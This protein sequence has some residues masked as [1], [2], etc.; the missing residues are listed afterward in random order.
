MARRERQKKKILLLIGLV[1]VLAVVGVGAWQFKKMQ[2]AKMVTQKRAAGLAA[3]EAGDHEAAFR[4]LQYVHRKDRTDGEVALALAESRRAVPMLNN[5]HLSQAM[6]FAR[7]AV[8][9][10]PDNLETQQ[11]LMSI[12]SE[13]GQ[14]TE[15]LSA[16]L[17]VQRIDPGN[18]DAIWVEIDSLRLLGRRQE[19]FDRALQF[20]EMFPTDPDASRAVVDLMIATNR[21]EEDVIA[22]VEEASAT[23][24]DVVRIQ[25]LKARVYGAYGRIEE[26]RA[27][28]LHAA[29]MEQNDAA[30]LA[31]TIQL[32]DVLG[33]TATVDELLQ[34]ESENPSESDMATVVAASRAWKDARLIDAVRRLNASERSLED[35]SSEL[36]AWKAIILDEDQ[37]A[38]A[39]AALRTR[40]TDEA[41]AWVATLDARERIRAK[42][43]TEAANDA[44][45]AG[46]LDPR[47][48]MAMFLLGETERAVGDWRSAIDRWRA[49]RIVE[50]RWLTLRLDIVSALLNAG[51]TREAYTEAIQ[52]FREWPDRLIVAQALGRSG[53]SLMERGQ[54]TPVERTQLLNVLTEIERQANDPVVGLA[55]LTRAHAA[56]GDIAMARETLGRLLAEDSLPPNED[57]IPLIEACRQAEIFGV[58][59]LV[60]KASTNGIADP[61]LI[62]AAAMVAHANGRSREGESLIDNAIKAETTDSTHQLALKRIRAIYF[63]RTGDSRALDALKE[64]AESDRANPEAQLALLNSQAAWT[65]RSAVRS[66]ITA[67]RNSSGESSA[68]WKVFEAR[69]VLTFEPTE[70]TAAQVVTLLQD[71]VRREP[72]NVGALTFLGEAYSIL[73]DYDQAARMLGRAVDAQASS[74]VLNARLIELLQLAGETDQAETRLRA[75]ASL[76]GLSREQRARRA[77]LLLRQNMVELARRDL[78]A[79]ADSGDV[80]Y[81]SLSAQAAVRSGDTATAKS[82]FDAILNRPDRTVDAVVAAADFYARFEGIER[83]LQAMTQLPDTLAD[84][85]RDLLIA[86]FHQRH[87]DVVMADRMYA[88]IAAQTGDAEAWIALARLRAARGDATGAL[89]AAKQGIAAHPNNRSLELLV[90][91]LEPGNNAT[92]TQALLKMVES[93]EPGDVKREPL[94]R[95]L[96]ARK[97]IDGRPNDVAFA[98]DQLRRVVEEYPGFYPAWQELAETL[99]AAGRHQEAAQ[100]AREAAYRLPNAANAAELATRALAIAKRYDEALPMAEEWSSRL[101]DDPYPAQLFIAVIRR[102]LGQNAQALARLEPWR[103]RIILEANQAPSIVVMYAGLLAEQG[104]RDEAGAI[105]DSLVASDPEWAV[106]R[107]SIVTWLDAQ[108]ANAKA[109]IEAWESSLPDTADAAAALGQAWYS[110][111]TRLGDVEL[112]QRALPPLRRALEESNYRLLAAI[113]LAG[114]Y[115]QLGDLDEAEKH[116]R[117]ALGESREEAVVLNNLA[118]LLVRTNGSSEEAVTL[119]RQ[120]VQLA[121][122]QNAAASLR[123]NYLDTLGSALIYAERFD[124]AAQAYDRAL[125]I[126]PDN[127]GA[128]LG[129]AESRLGEGNRQAAQDAVSRLLLLRDRGRI[130]DEGQQQRLAQILEQSGAQ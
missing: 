110:V 71:V 16:S 116:Y 45:R 2:E 4:D 47:N 64:V 90:Y 5:R 15:R 61:G 118:Y 11:L 125:Q 31:A 88:A 43:W 117:I 112:L 39:T 57:L 84:N 94:E 24:P 89:N 92:S 60:E 108:P 17:E 68:A 105:F 87:G 123:V 35:S 30:T 107:L 7:R 97:A 26:A 46:E 27:T 96:A 32:L 91:A 48:E 3:H 38:A 52:T 77:Q 75:F 23:A 69:E 40:D 18:R 95:Y 127:V 130:S 25:Q 51:Q 85:D 54:A 21:D 104:R 76:D 70:K 1:A 63:D 93:L 29:G 73:K 41:R 115:E 111:A 109:W 82:K 59:D 19:A 74:A 99:S 12:Y 122:Q 55:L 121:E 65:E 58:A 113:M 8:E 50:P 102:E 103:D 33:E 78:D 9:I 100:V 22:F 13:M 129:L 53:V 28:A 56:A 83:G 119:A 14:L 34:R 10:E 49:L 37:A 20:H 101:N 86:A 114:A 36:L 106:R 6:Q 72:D 124:E 98:T 81:V 67:L 62:L 79:L 42:D 128:L 126:T 44:R 80:T 120:G 66:A